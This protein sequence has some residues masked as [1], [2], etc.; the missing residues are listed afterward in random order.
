M[1]M[2]VF[3][4]SVVSVRG[5]CWSDGERPCTSD[6]QGDLTILYCHVF[7]WMVL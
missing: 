5:N 1:E 2:N 4:L 6:T 7:F 3:V